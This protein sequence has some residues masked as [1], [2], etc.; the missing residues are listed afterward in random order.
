MIWFLLLLPIYVIFLAL[1]AIVAMP[2]KDSEG[3]V[4][5]FADIFFGIVYFFMLVSSLVLILR[6]FCHKC[7]Q[8]S[9]CTCPAATFYSPYDGR[10]ICVPRKNI[11]ASFLIRSSSLELASNGLTTQQ[12]ETT[13]ID[14]ES[15]QMRYL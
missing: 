15:N 6:Y 12:Y 9:V 11:P 7:D 3:K 2:T 10:L 5:S 8:R 1:T 4:K 13:A 14:F